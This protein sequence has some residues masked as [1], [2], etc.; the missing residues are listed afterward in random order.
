[1]AETLHR[2][3]YH[4]TIDDAVDVA[5]RLAYQTQAFRK[6]IRTNI[7]IGGAVAGVVF[8]WVWVSFLAGPGPFD[9]AIAAIGALV[10]GVVFALMFKGFLR[11]EILKQHRKI[12]AEQF[13]GQDTIPTE[14][15]LRD[16]AVWVRQGGIEL[17]F[18]WAICTAVRDNAGDIEINF[19]QGICVIRN[20][21]FGSP[22]EREQFLGTA[23]RLAGK[24]P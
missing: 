11:K 16:D 3:V 7:I 6:Q 12:V 15:E 20:R 14:L 2:I 18:P 8:L 4:A 13:G 23:R 1:M 22:A 17:I 9:L 21:D 19:T 10:F 24:A 5:L